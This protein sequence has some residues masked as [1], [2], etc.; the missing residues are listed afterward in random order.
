MKM[1]SLGRSA[2]NRAISFHSVARSHIGKV[3]S[4]NEDRLLDC[5]DRRL[6]AI[7]DGMGGHHFGDK[8][9]TMV[10]RALAQVA[11]MAEVTSAKT[12]AG[13]LEGVNADVMAMARK[14]GHVCG[15]TV[16]ALHIHGAKC[17]VLWAGDS[18]IY[19]FRDAKLERL[20]RD[21][22]V[23]QDMADKG[24]ITEMQGRTHPQSNV[25]TR[26]IGIDEHSNVEQTACSVKAGDL[27]LVC[28]D[29]LSASID[30]HCLAT[31]LTAD[32]ESSANK[33]MG[34]ALDAGGRDNISFILVQA[35]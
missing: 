15:S 34:A 3:R 8:A 31:L 4:V 23:V 30:D 9:A 28:S 2:Q 11:E 35:T 32:L 21:H 19:R 20:S 22:S 13:A 16:A 1:F 25:I 33:M 12:V 6:W 24:L 29:G 27:F 10:V 7:A 26:A 18:R 5:P 17:T 14:A